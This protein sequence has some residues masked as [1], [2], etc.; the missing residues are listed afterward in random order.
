MVGGESITSLD[1]QTFDHEPEVGDQ[2]KRKKV[3]ISMHH[4]VVERIKQ[5]KRRLYVCRLINSTVVLV[6]FVL[7]SE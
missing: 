1:C 4:W 6:L 5:D 2:Q 7:F 3:N